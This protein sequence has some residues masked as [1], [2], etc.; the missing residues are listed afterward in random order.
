MRCRDT[1]PV[2]HAKLT[3]EGNNWGLVCGEDDGAACW[4]VVPLVKIGDEHVCSAA[5]EISPTCQCGPFGGQ[6]AG[7]W[8][9]WQHF[10]PDH[11]G[12]MTKEEWDRDVMKR[13]AKMKE[14]HD[15]PVQ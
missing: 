8:I 13:R 2:P 9:V 14:A 4:H 10:D 15:N 3:N 11:A 6:G 12:A 1:T 5:H 7:G